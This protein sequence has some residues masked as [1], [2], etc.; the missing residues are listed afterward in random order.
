MGTMSAMGMVEEAGVNELTL[1]W[2]LQSNHYPPIPKA[3]IPVALEAIDAYNEEDV[4]RTISL[5]DI[6]QFQGKDSAPA[7]EIVDYM[8]LHSFIDYEEE[9]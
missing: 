2:H 8:H 1:G 7:Y 5:R 3:M 4:E 6:C 9:L